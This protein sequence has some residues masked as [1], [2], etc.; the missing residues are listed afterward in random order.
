MKSKMLLR[1]LSGPSKWL[2]TIGLVAACLA[3][4]AWLWL[5]WHRGKTVIPSHTYQLVDGRMDDWKAVGGDWTIANGVIY[6][7]S[8]ER[9]SKLLTGSSTWG[10][11]AVNTD[12]RFEGVNADIGVIIRTNDEKKKVPT[13]TTG[14]TSVSAPWMERW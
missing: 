6:N 3:A 13:P 2:L 8:N 4:L 10:D 7:N 11:Y 5:G 12:V 14:T 1:L 9:G